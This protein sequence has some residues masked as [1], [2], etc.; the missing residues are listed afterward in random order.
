[1]NSFD[2]HTNGQVPGPAL[3]SRREAVK[4]GA[5][6]LTGLYAGLTPARQ[7]VPE[8]RQPEQPLGMLDGQVALV[9]GA[10]RGIG[11]ACAVALARAGAH[12]VALD[13][14]RSIEGH[15]IPLATHGDLA[16]TARAVEA[17]GKRCL[18]VQ[19][20]TRDLSQLQEAVKRTLQE[21]GRLD[22]LVANAG[23]NAPTKLTEANETAWRN[24]VDVNVHGTVNAMMAVLPHMTGRQQGRI[25]AISSTFGR[26][27]NAGNANYVASKWAIIGLVK[28]AAIEVGP[29]NI[30]V[31]AVAPTGVRTG[32]G[33][34]RTEEQR[35][36]AD[37]FFQ[38]SYHYLPV[39]SLEPEDIAGAVVFLTSPQARYITGTTLDVAAGANA[40]YTG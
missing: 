32:L 40:R 28:A 5:S 1:M 27:G 38:E 19:A 7:P 29:A 23:I 25:I 8:Y 33:G 11:R 9:T 13:I 6:A 22:I 16:E 14:A 34:P 36:Q 26:Q 18:T 21:L 2:S 4:A 39:G 10:G 20:D 35:A 37:K 15:P 31:N 12:V 17:T 30:T 3:L 24:V